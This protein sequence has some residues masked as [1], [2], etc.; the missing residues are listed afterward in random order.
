VSLELSQHVVDAGTI[1]LLVLCL[2]EP[3]IGLKG[4]A[5]SESKNEPNPNRLFKNSVGPNRTRTGRVRFDSLSG[6]P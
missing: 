2:Q 3:E 5:A 6:S 1:S 4:V